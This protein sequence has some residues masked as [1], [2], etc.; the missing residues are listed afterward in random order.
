MTAA[1]GDIVFEIVD[2]RGPIVCGRIQIHIPGKSG[3]L[4]E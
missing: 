1:K 4:N 2:E 3:S